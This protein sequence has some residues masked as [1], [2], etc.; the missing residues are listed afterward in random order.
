MSLKAKLGRLDGTRLGAGPAVPLAQRPGTT[1]G[2]STLARALETPFLSPFGQVHRTE[3]LHDEAF[4]QGR[5]RVAEAA[6]V[7]AQTLARLA[8]EPGLEQVAPEKMLFLDTETTGLHGGTGTVPF[9][10][11]LAY[12]E[13][14]ALRVEQLFLKRLGEEKP[15][16]KVL[17]GHMERASMWV[18]YNG[19][20]FDWPLLKNRLVLNRLPTPPPRPH[21]DLLHV[22]RRVFK[23]RL[24]TARLKELEVGVLGY[25][26]QGDIDGALIPQSYFDFLK[27][28]DTEELETVLEHNVQDLVSLA[29]LLAD[30]ARLFEKT[31]A[32]DAPQD[33]LSMAH[34]AWKA[35]E[36]ARAEA[37]ATEVLRTSTQPHVLSEACSLLASLHAKDRNFP[38][39]V[40]ALEEAVALPQLP[41]DVK[42]RL[43]LRL[44][45]L[46]EH[47]LSRLDRALEHARLSA[48]AEHAHLH[49]RRL[50]R[51][52]RRLQHA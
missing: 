41:G 29:A 24:G 23:P 12:F 27:T 46:Y 5:V 6:S 47:R 38:K 45:K 26:R 49:A 34:V 19:K 40:G 39:A 8:R 37:L 33:C 50:A 28:H 14:G 22:C 32:H 51:L 36:R 10:V 30:V 18:T 31:E 16:L 15:L 42:Q 3:R 48:P 44:A 25:E 52:S 13:K 9:L 17:S 4:R 2:P 7:Q 1:T 21:L 43:H 35:G 20:C 11:G